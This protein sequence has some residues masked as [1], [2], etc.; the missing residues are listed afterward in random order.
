MKTG[1]NK[2]FI[3]VTKICFFLSV[4]G[5]FNLLWFFGP[6]DWA[7]NLAGAQPLNPTFG[8]YRDSGPG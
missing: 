6:L 8:P 5:F 7:L 1:L 4:Y 3:L 2:L